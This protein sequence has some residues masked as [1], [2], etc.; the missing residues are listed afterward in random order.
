MTKVKGIMLTEKGLVKRVVRDNIASI[1]CKKIASLGYEKVENKSVLV[2]E[3]VDTNG[4]MVYATISITISPNDPRIEKP[5]KE[6]S[7]KDRVV[8]TFEIVE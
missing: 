5:K 4:N 7:S 8:E 3:Y 6:K 2:N 1:E